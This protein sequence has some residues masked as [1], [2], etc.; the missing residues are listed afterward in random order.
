MKNKNST[1]FIVIASSFALAGW[2]KAGPPTVDDVGDVGSFGN[3]AIYMGAAS[4]DITLQTAPCTTPTPTPTPSPPSVNPPNG[5]Q[6]FQIMDTTVTTPFDAENS[7]RINLPLNAAKT[8][9]YPVLNFFYT[10]NMNNTT[11]SAAQARFQFTANLTIVSTV[12]NDP[13]CIDPNTGAPCDGRLTFQFTPNRVFD[14]RHL[15]AGEHA[16]VRMTLTRAGNG[17]ISKA[18]LITEGLPS[19]LVDNLFKNPMTLQMNVIGTAQ[20]VDFAQITTNMRLFG[21]H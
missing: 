1:F 4:G 9:I 13:S 7:C 8:I 19:S 17:G 10:Y 18:S 21:D 12:L 16:E 11:A 14:D 15:D 5:E 20:Y 2:L 3:N 6:C